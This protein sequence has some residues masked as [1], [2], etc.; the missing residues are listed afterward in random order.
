MTAQMTTL[1]DILP[2][3]GGSIKTGPFGTK[4]SASEYTLD[5]APVISVGEIGDGRLRVS[6][7]TRR[8]PPD[9]SR[10]MPEYVL[11]PGDIVF[12]RKGAVDRSA[13][14][15]ASESGYFLGSDGIRLRLGSGVAPEYIAHWMQSSV[16]RDWLVRHSVGTTMLTLTPPVLETL[17]IRLPELDEQIRV[18]DAL[19]DA[20]ALISSIQDSLVKKRDIKLGMMQELLTGR[21]RLPSFSGDWHVRTIGDVATVV[22]GQS[23]SGRSYNTTGLGVPLIQGNADIRNRRTFDRV[24][25]TEPT[26]RVRVNDVVLTV[27]APV[28]YTGIAMSDACLGRGVCGISAGKSTP[29]LFHALVAAEPTWALHEQGSTFTAVNSAQLRAFEI[30]WP[31]EAGERAAIAQVLTDAGAEIDLVER[32]LSVARD[33]KRGMMQELL[34]GRTRLLSQE[35]VA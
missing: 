23:P 24:W 6:E 3:V 31:D 10:R 1:G 5:G 27:R 18:A 26:K 12:G 28:G 34:T 2:R 17:P 20:D 22:M 25:T 16:A 9:V 33:T 13:I 11:R 35:V 32:R 8:V 7:E 29:F 19:S 4:L 21:T 30:S 15:R 14:V